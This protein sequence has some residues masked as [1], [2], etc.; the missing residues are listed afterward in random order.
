MTHYHAISHGWPTHNGTIEDLIQMVHDND[1]DLTK[2]ELLELDEFKTLQSIMDEEG[3]VWDH[4]DGVT[5]E[6]NMRRW[7]ASRPMLS[8]I[9]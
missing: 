3:F 9:L 4:T 8:E 7:E 5:V 1:K 6:R 2:I